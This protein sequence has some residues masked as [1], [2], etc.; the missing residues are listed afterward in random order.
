MRGL[1]FLAELTPT[2][3]N[4]L[5]VSHDVPY[6]V[7]QSR[8]AT[9]RVVL[10]PDQQLGDK[11][12]RAISF[13]SSISTYPRR[14]YRRLAELVRHCPIPVRPTQHVQQMRRSHLVA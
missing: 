14:E 5:S 6:C 4:S 2:S 13:A 10:I 8:V 7:S 11:R 9:G 1:C 3:H 12:V